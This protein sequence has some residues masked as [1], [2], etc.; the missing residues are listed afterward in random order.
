VDIAGDFPGIFGLQDPRIADSDDL[1]GAPQVMQSD[2][3]AVDRSGHGLEDAV[4]DGKPSLVRLDGRRAWTNLHF[5]PVI[6]FGP[7]DELGLAPKTQIGRI[8]N[9][10]GPGGD[11]GMGT[12]EAGIEPIKLL[13]ED[14]YIA[15]VGLGDERESFHA[16][17]VLGLGEGNADAIARVGAVG[18]EVLAIQQGHAGVFDA[19][20]FI[21]ARRGEKGLGIG[22]E[23]ESVGAAGQTDDG[24]AGAEMGTEQHDVLV[25]MLHHGCVVDGFHGVGDIGFGEDGI[26]SVSSDH[27]LASS[28]KM[29]W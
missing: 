16:G 17:E 28:S 24:P 25:R 3:Q 22:G 9:P 7:H 5:V 20:L 11:F 14:H 6:G 2:P 19:E 29:V 15:I 10:D 1:G 8:G 12:V 18:D 23:V 27:R 4:I 13:G 21:C 26:V